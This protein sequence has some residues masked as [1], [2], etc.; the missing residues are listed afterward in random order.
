MEDASILILTVQLI[1][2]VGVGGKE[3]ALPLATGNLH[4]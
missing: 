1:A 3:T 2:E 4:R